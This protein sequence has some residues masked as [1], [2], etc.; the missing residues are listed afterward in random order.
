MKYQNVHYACIAYVSIDS[1][2]KIITIDSV[3]KIKKNEL[4]AS[5]FRR[6]QIQNKA[7]KDV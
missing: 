3:M 1:V 6:M 7:N 2:M 4:S 5:L